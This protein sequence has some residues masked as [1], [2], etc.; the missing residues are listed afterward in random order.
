MCRDDVIDLE[1]LGH[2]SVAGHTHQDLTCP[3]LP[4][5]V[6]VSLMA[7]T[8]TDVP[9]TRNTLLQTKPD[10]LCEMILVRIFFKVISTMTGNGFRSE[11]QILHE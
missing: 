1:T 4:I 6:L 10:S 9:H 2:D 5:D 7:A 3:A 11:H 8:H